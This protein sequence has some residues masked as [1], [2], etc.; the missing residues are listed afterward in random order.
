MAKRGRS[1]SPEG[2]D[3]PEVADQELTAETGEY[4]NNEEAKAAG[5]P[6]AAALL[7]FPGKTFI[8]DGANV[9][10]AKDA[11]NEAKAD[12]ATVKHPKLA[13]FV[14][15]SFAPSPDKPSG[16]ALTFLRCAPKSA[17]NNRYTTKLWQTPNSYNLDHDILNAM[18]ILQGLLEAKSE[19][20]A[21]FANP[22]FFRRI[23]QVNAATVRVFSTC[24]PI[25]KA[26]QHQ[27][28]Q[29]DYPPITGRLFSEIVKVSKNLIDDMAK[30]APNVEFSLEL[31]WHPTKFHTAQSAFEVAKRARLV[32]LGPVAGNQL[33]DPATGVFAMIKQELRALATKPNRDGHPAAKRLRLSSPSACEEEPLDLLHTWDSVPSER[34]FSTSYLLYRTMMADKAKLGHNQV[35]FF[36]VDG[37]G[38]VWPVPILVMKRKL[39]G[40]DVHGLAKVDMA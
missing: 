12:L 19:L 33:M 40:P 9:Q 39:F 4:C 37:C 26:L 10:L 18:A 5:S 32:R 21:A 36:I 2:D 30:V 8:S 3:H 6:S 29:D 11:V 7:Q 28:Q 1:P 24:K 16:Y 17:W 34:I 23:D 38:T 27:V 22:N 15:G 14:A 31:H 35:F 25:L 13:I 20:D